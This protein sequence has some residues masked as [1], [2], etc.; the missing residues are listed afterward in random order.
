MSGIQLAA[1]TGDEG[2][3]WSYDRSA[4]IV[5]LSRLRINRGVYE[6]GRRRQL[7]YSIE[8][9]GE[10]RSTCAVPANPA[11]HFPHVPGVS[12]QRSLCKAV[13]LGDAVQ[14]TLLAES[15]TFRNDIEEDIF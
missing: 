9:S 6:R 1:V 5:E 7:K 15:A 3:K 13:Q 11:R 12:S 4:V 10:H 2:V 14:F 8:A